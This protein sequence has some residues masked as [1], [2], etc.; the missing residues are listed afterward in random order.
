AKAEEHARDEDLEQRVE[1]AEPA[2]AEA[3]LEQIRE[4]R[5]S[6]AAKPHVHEPEIRVHEHGLERQPR[7]RRALLVD[8]ARGADR[9]LRLGR[10]AEVEEKLV[11]LP[12]RAA[13]EE[14]AVL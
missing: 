8:E 5:Q 7:P 4:R 2:A 9:A 11:Q 3:I 12:K 6:H 14:E 13:G 1:H 10:V